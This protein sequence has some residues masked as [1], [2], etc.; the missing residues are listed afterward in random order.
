MRKSTAAGLVAAL[1]LSLLPAALPAPAEAAP[2]K[3]IYVQKLDMPSDWPVKS[4][5]RWLD[6]YTG[7][8]TFRLVKRC[9]AKRDCVTVQTGKLSGRNV[10]WA[11]PIRAKTGATH[12]T[13]IVVIDPA[14]AKRLRYSQADRKWLLVHEFGHVHALPHQRKRISVMHPDLPRPPMVLTPA[15]RRHLARR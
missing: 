8:S 14:K 15:E 11:S 13:S 2:Q 4:A 10:G 12:R 1:T 3:V 5:L 9:P 6:V 7:K